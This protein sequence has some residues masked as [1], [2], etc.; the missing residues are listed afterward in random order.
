MHGLTCILCRTSHVEAIAGAHALKLLERINLV[1][2]LLAAAYNL[3][4]KLLDVDAL[5][6]ALF[7]FDE[8]GRTVEGNAAVVTDD[9]AAAV[10]IGQARDDVRMACS[11]DI[12]V[13]GSKDTLIV[14]LAILG[15]DGLCPG[16]ELITIGLER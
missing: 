12:I 9:A 13:I 3:L 6:E 14:R 4:G 10:S 2:N 1:S 7:L 11:L 8:V 16:V 15:V 5:V